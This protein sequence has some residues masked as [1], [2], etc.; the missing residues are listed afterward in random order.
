MAKYRQYNVRGGFT[1]LE[2]LLGILIFS[3]IALSL[4]STFAAGVHLNRRSEQAL[5]IQREAR[6]T[7]DQLSRDL[8]NMV[9]YD[10][11]GSYPELKSFMAMTAAVSFL[12]TAAHGLQAVRYQVQPIEHGSVFT[13]IK[14]ITSDRNVR[15]VSGNLNNIENR[16]WALTREIQDF[17]AFL[18]QGFEGA[19]REILSRSIPVEGFRLEFAALPKRS[20]QSLRW[21]N[22]WEGKAIPKGVRLRLTLITGE[23]AVKAS[24][25]RDVFIPTGSWHEE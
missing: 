9:F 14:G 15:V 1:L 16:R 17:R 4:Y 22:S 24:F 20:T 19:S 13:T 6:W 3:V 25:V 2:M 8:E 18:T 7:L 21:V 12:K 5:K 10:F 11:S 23:P